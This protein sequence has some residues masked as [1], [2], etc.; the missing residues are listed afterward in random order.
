MVID[1]L[2]P[3]TEAQKYRIPKIW[4]GELDSPFG[5]DLTSAN[6]KGELGFIITKM[7][8]DPQAGEISYGRL[9]SGTA[10][11]GLEVYLNN[12][13]QKSRIQQV[14]VANG[15]KR[16]LVE[17]LPA[18]NIIGI[19]G[20]KAFPGETV[21]LTEQ[22][23]FEA[24]SHIFEPVITKAIKP[25]KPGDLPKMIEVLRQVSKEDPS[26]IIEI[27]EETGESLMHGMGEL[28]LEIIENRIVS[29]KGLKVIT[30][31]PIVTYRESITKPSGTF[32]GK[33]PNKHNKLF[34]KVEPLNPE[35]IALI[36]NGE[37]SPG[38]IKRK[39]ENL[40]KTLEKGG[41]DSKTSRKVKDVFEGNMFVDQVRGCVH[42]NE[43]MEM[44]LDM[45][46]DVMHSGPQVLDPCVNTKVTLV[47]VKLHED[48]IH[49]GPG[50]LYP[51]VREGIRLAI[52]DANPLLL[53]PVQVIQID[54]PTDYAGEVSKL[55]QNKRGQLLEMD[56]QGVMTIVKAK[57]PV[58]EML[59]WSSDLRS[60][61]GGMG[62]SSIIDQEF[63]QLPHVLQDK[64]KKDII[65][66]KGVKEGQLGA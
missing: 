52:L 23:P 30:S 64:V 47:D 36:K 43:I 48:A 20:L 12:A 57:M 17:S 63:Q 18:G 21:T 54:A 11:K 3:P 65:K 19:A 59:G 10:R 4:K 40:W 44:V 13:K 45:F 1:K 6:P 42:I 5:K 60:A 34:F 28:H 16:E 58:G 27:N 51:A 29:E 37:I 55:V 41:M 61:T 53:E 50:Q 38:R 2:P 15:A 9:F 8:I 66:R 39:D 7:I 33:S 14:F 26:I 25:E 22:E 24:I 56:A 31:P 32:E 49:R 46:E 62:V 35:M